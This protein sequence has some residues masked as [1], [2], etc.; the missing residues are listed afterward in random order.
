MNR[1]ANESF[2]ILHTYIAIF[3]IALITIITFNLD[4][5][6]PDLTNEVRP[7][8]IKKATSYVDSE[9][10]S[11]EAKER[12]CYLLATIITPIILFLSLSLFYRYSSSKRPFRNLHTGLVI[13]SY[14]TIL[15]IIIL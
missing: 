15:S 12:H 11:I 5:Q 3:V 13:F 2:L 6:I 10:L 4:Y 14:F 8:I 1:L 7:I 9:S